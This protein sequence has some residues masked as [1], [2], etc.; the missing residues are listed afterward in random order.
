MTCFKARPTLLC[1]LYISGGV[2]SGKTMLMDTF[3]AELAAAGF[4]RGS[5]HVMANAR[6]VHFNA[7]MLEVR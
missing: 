6:R 7:A 3:F 2:G 1:R 5:P 4:M